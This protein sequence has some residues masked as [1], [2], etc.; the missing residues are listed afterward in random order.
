MFAF[1]DV[2]FK[3][4][5]NCSAAQAD[6]QIRD[7]YALVVITSKVKWLCVKTVLYDIR[8]LG[9][10]GDAAYLIKDGEV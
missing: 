4:I 8:C 9:A 1:A 5:Q 10:I 2:T 3:E 7:G 6:T